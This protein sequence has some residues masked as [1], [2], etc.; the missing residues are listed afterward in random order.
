[1]NENIIHL[2]PPE[3]NLPNKRIGQTVGKETI[4]QCKVSASPQE[5]I[6]WTKN[7]SALPQ[8]YKYFTELYDDGHHQKTLNLNIIDIEKEDFGSYTCEA[9]NT[10]GRDSETMLLYGK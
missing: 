3:V 5:S 8:S 2:D 7:G 9:T 6:I 1:M 10:L 4:L